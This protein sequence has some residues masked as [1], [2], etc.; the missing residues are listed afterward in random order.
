M[1]LIHPIFWYNPV[2][3]EKDRTSF[4]LMLSNR[5]LKWFTLTN[6]FLMRAKALHSM[7]TCLMVKGIWHV[8]HC[9]C[10]SCFSMKEWV[11]L[12]R[13]MHNRDK[14]TCSHLDFLKLVSIFP[15]WAGFGKSYCGCYYSIIVAI[16]CEE[17]YWFGVSGQYMESWICQGSHLLISML[18][19]YWNTVI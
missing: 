17:I 1:V 18:V 9:G 7:R 6:R 2:S 3:L 10:C 15:K 19:V 5:S 13:P 8:K 11:S 16:L 12:V 4:I 14:M